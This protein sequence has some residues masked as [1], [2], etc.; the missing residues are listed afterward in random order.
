MFFIVDSDDFLFD[1]AIEKIKKYE[2]SLNNYNNFAGIGGSRT[3]S[4]NNPSSKKNKKDV[5]DC[6]SLERERYNILGDK[7]EVYYTDLL[8]RYKFPIVKGERFITE[9]VLWHE[10]A[11]NNYKM[12]WVNDYF[13]KGEYL[14]DGYSNKLSSLFQKN[15]I[16]Y[17]I[18]IRNESKYH[19]LDI[20]MKMGNYYRYYE[21]MKL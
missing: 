21:I 2:I 4:N 6:T 19:P 1:D 15:P 17:L 7:A 9:C 5:L 20:K 16:S 18:H 3:D 12:R 11:Y 10:I 8:R 14:P 13:A